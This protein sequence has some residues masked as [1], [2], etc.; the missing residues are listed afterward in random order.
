MAAKNMK[1]GR[2]EIIVGSMIG[3]CASLYILFFVFMELAWEYAKCPPYCSYVEPQYYELT[4][5]ANICL[6][7]AVVLM[8]SA[9]IMGTRKD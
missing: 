1:I 8:V 9:V 2:G 3:G 6:I 5:I 4:G 7:G